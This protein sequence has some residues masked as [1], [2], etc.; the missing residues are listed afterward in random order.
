M[1]HAAILA[2]ISELYDGNARL[3]AENDALRAEVQRLSQ[4]NPG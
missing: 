1:N 3:Q 2:L 4:T